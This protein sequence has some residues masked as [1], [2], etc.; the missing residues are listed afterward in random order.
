VKPSEINTSSDK[1]RAHK[2]CSNFYDNALAKYKDKPINLFEIGIDSGGSIRMWREYFTQAKIYCMDINQ[3]AVGFVND[4]DVTALV[5]N[6]YDPTVIDTLPNFD[7]VIDDGPHT[8]ESQL[9]CLDLY[10]PK[11]N[12]G[13]MLVI[14]DILDERSVDKFKLRVPLNC[15]IE[16]RDIRPKSGLP[17]SILFIVRK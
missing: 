17:E 3:G 13:G 10:I 6:A 15:Y 12:T 4:I 14:E 16:V 8:E 5:G 7:I 11:L 9:K 1:E 2:Y